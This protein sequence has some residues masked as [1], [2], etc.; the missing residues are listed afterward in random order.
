MHR[1]NQ[2]EEC[3]EIA[4]RALRYSLNHQHEDGSWFYAE[5][6]SAHWIDSFHTS[7]NLQA[8]KYFLEEGHGEEHRQ[9]F[10]MGS[11]FYAENFFLADG[12]PKYYHDRTYPIDIHSPAQALVFFSALGEAQRGLTARI[13]QWALTNMRSKKGFFYF[14]KHKCWTNKIPYMRW[15]QAWMFHAL[16]TCEFNSSPQE[17]MPC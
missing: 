15:S 14:Q 7:F 13:L 11:K 5:K 1:F 17:R 8:L 16:T 2:N 10:E 3:R 4:L 6:E 9:A 12:T